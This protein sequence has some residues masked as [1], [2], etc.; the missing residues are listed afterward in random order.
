MMAQKKQE[1]DDND[2][3]DAA[4]FDLISFHHPHLGDYDGGQENEL[5]LL[6]RHSSLLAHYL[7]SASQLLVASGAVHVA[8]CGNQAASW[9]LREAAVRAGLLL[10]N[11]DSRTTTM[12]VIPVQRPFHH[13]L[14][15]ADAEQQE[16]IFPGTTQRTVQPA[17][18]QLLWLLMGPW[19]NKQQQQPRRTVSKR[20]GGSRH[21]LG[22]YGYRHVRTA[23]NST[24]APNLT[25]SQHYVFRRRQQ[26]TKEGDDEDMRNTANTTNNSNNGDDDGD[27]NATY[28]CSICLVAF[29]TAAELQAHLQEPATPVTVT[30]AAA[31][32][33][34]LDKDN[35][36]NSGNDGTS[37]STTAASRSCLRI[38]DRRPEEG[39]VVLKVLEEGKRLRWCLQHCEELLPPRRSRGVW[40]RI[41]K[42]GLVFVN[43]VVAVDTGRILQAG[44]EIELRLVESE[45]KDGGAVVLKNL[46]ADIEIVDTWGPKK[47]CATTT[48]GEVYVVWKPVGM[49]AI[50]SFDA[51]TLE[52]SFNVQQQKRNQDGEAIKYQSLSKLDTGCSG[53]CVLA[54]S[55]TW[56]ESDLEIVHTFVALVHGHVPKEWLSG[57]SIE[58]PTDAV[59]RWKKRATNNNEDNSNNNNKQNYR[60]NNKRIVALHVFNAWR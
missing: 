47:C 30:A 7:D 57:V 60:P 19:N 10:E 26:K 46:P 51:S 45:K 25:G 5:A 29:A 17:G 41:I 4:P 20:H 1:D 13:V 37:T 28:S 24:A 35:E 58:L 3:D 42:D 50:G 2:T 31:A 52:E 15:A 11:D 16:E 14:N 32:A 44:W 56:Q 6:Q 33:G 12:T 53:L 34:V 39:V 8:L 22:K 9:R 55:I 18:K 59:R 21:W 23:P 40:D 54:P 27:V 49:R 43:G 36:R 48:K 38:L